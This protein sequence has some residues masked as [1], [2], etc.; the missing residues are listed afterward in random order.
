MTLEVIDQIT[1]GKERATSYFQNKENFLSLL[2]IFLNRRQDIE[3]AFHEL[4]HIKDLKTVTGVWLDYIGSIVGQDRNG[5]EDEAYRAQIQLRIAINN[6]DG[7][8]DS[9]R[10]IVK[11][12]T[13]SDNVRIGEGIY[14]YGQLLFD[15]TG[16]ATKNLFDTVED[17]VP[18]GTKLLVA[19]NTDNE[20]VLPAWEVSTVNVDLFYINTDSGE[21]TLQ[22][23]LSS[24]SDPS[25]LYVATEGGE[26]SLDED[27]DN[28]CLL[29]WELSDQF[30]LSNREIFEISLD[31]VTAEP[32]YV[33]GVAG[34]IEGNS[35]L[36]WEISED[37]NIVEGNWYDYLLPYYEDEDGIESI[38]NS[39]E[40][41]VE[42]LPLA[43]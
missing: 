18:V 2:E 28:A 40:D 14:S 11:A 1:L 37:S 22:L 6:S 17:I 13:S 24:Y 5:A 34:E 23:V 12:Y 20:C 19:Q 27:T 36:P 39:L 8:F 7:T 26:V 33:S 38:F 4:T 43:Q 10:S 35:L 15:G 31:G 42:N 3:N 21:D 9:V 41:T 32:L 30:L 16:N 25:A 29:A